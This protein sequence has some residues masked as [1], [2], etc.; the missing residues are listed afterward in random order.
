MVE[1]DKPG[2]RMPLFSRLFNTTKELFHGQ[3]TSRATIYLF[4]SSFCIYDSFPTNL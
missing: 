2:E 4:C 1:G 3:K